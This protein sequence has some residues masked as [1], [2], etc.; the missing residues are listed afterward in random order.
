VL[1][2]ALLG[3]PADPLLHAVRAAT[4][5]FGEFER[6]GI[7]DS[8]FFADDDK[9][10]DKKR[11]K[12]DA[13]VR[14]QVFRASA[15][16][17]RIASA[18]LAAN[19]GDRE[20]LFA[21]CTAVGIETD[22]AA[23][24]EK[25]YFRSYSLSKESQRHARRLL[26]LDPPDYDAFVTVGAVE[27][28]VGN[29]NFFFRLFIRF[30]QIEGSRQKAVEN[31]EKVVAHGRYFR[32]FA[33][34]LLAAIHMREKRPQQALTHLREYDREFPGTRLILKEIARAEEQLRALPTRRR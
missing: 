10:T 22:Y 27:Y 2:T 23:L 26:D 32:P 30:D 3:N 15:E 12:P 24:V 1:D 13:A 18:R 25:R 9:V 11:L 4:Y 33:R 7:L 8:E 21:L 16:A 31:L 28:V 14:T 19:S 5:L 29:L 17:R 34:L 20:A 6:L